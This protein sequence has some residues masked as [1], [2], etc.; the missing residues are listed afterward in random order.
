MTSELPYKDWGTAC[1][2]L[3]HRAMA[4][5]AISSFSFSAGRKFILRGLRYTNTSSI[6]KNHKIS[7]TLY[8]RLVGHK[9]FRGVS[10][11]LRTDFSATL[12]TQ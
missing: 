1:L 9:L 4:L 11:I 5:N 8:D 3:T 7:M 10:P 6:E 12:I 2:L